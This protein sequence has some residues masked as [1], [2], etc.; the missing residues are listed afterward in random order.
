MYLF[1]KYLCKTV[2]TL[3]FKSIYVIGIENIPQDCPV[4]I[5]GNHSNQFIDAFML[6]SYCQ[7]ALSFTM[8][9]GSFTK[10]LIGEFAK[11][12]GA[13]PIYRPEDLKIKGK[14]KAKIEFPNIIKVNK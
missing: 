6:L 10:R 14:G 7:R 8:A 5:C 4:I 13:I 12:I 1:V 9:S 2:V 11:S 3:Y